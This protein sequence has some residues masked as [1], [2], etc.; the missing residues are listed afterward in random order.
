[1]LWSLAF[2]R[3]GVVVSDIYFLDPDPIPGQEGAER[4]VRLELRR[5]ERDKLNGSIYSAVPIHIGKPI[6]RVD[7]LESVS[8][9]PGSLDRAHHHPR[10]HG[11][12]PTQRVFVDELSASPVQ[13]VRDQFAQIDSVLDH[14]HY[15]GDELETNDVESLRQ[16]GPT[17]ANMVEYLLDEIREGRGARPPAATGTEARE[18]WL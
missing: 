15:S 13:W 12:E 17:V 16:A 11:W 18:S 5:F 6:W 4:G 8:S 2:D 14:A 3:I 9:E 1:M 10:F 7:L